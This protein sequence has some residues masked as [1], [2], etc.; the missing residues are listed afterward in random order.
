MSFGIR[1]VM[2]IGI[3]CSKIKKKYIGLEKRFAL[4]TFQTLVLCIVGLFFYVC[5]LGTSVA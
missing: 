4:L 1:G 5:A 3:S 2:V